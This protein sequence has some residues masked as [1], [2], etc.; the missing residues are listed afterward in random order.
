MSHNTWIHR[1]V[2]VSLVKPLINIPVTPNHLTTARLLTGIA[3]A[4]LVAKGEPRWMDTR[5]IFYWLLS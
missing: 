5:Q 3:A 4:A 1:V 2:R